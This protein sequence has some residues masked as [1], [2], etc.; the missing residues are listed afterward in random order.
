MRDWSGG[1]LDSPS[2]SKPAGTLRRAAAWLALS[3]FIGTALLIAVGCS[4][5]VLDFAA[6]SPVVRTIPDAGVRRAVTGFLFGC[7]GGLIALSPVGRVSGAHINPVVTLAFW[8]QKKLSGRLALIYIAAQCAGATLGAWA[9]TLWGPWAVSTHD[10]GTFPGPPGSVAAALGEM[11][12]TFCLVVGLFS[13]LRSARTRRFTPAIFPVLY[14]VMVY[15]EAPLSGTSTNPARS[16]GPEIVS[17]FW[18]GWWVYWAGPTLGSVAGVIFLVAVFPFIYEE[19]EVAKLYRFE[20]DPSG[21]FHHTRWQH[22]AGSPPS[23]QAKS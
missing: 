4:F 16:L 12:A 20:H 22:R 1:P 23:H 5:V 11:A 6:G 7:T 15:I 19:I 18:H 10:A 9:L 13:F 21:I 8:I 14:A 2:P 3:E 17:H